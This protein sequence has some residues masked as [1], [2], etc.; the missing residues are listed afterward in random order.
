MWRVKALIEGLVVGA[1]L[2]VVIWRGVDWYEANMTPGPIPCWEANWA[3]LRDRDIFYEYDNRDP[4]DDPPAPAFG[5][6][7]CAEDGK[8]WALSTA[9]RGVGTVP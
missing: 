7:H 4:D 2:S 8:F 6:Y 1:V 5:I 3:T 9:P